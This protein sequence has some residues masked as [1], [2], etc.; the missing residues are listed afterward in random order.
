M[1]TLRREGQTIGFR[2]LYYDVLLFSSLIEII[3]QA[4]P[5]KYNDTRT[6][7]TGNTKT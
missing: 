7:Q 3:P 2:L 5:T 1:S 4:N 6:N